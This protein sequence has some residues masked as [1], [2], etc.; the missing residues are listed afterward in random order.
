[1]YHFTECDLNIKSVAQLKDAYSQIGCTI[2]VADKR[3]K[4][5]WVQAILKHQSAQI[6][7][8]AVAEI[9]VDEQA[10]AQTELETHVALQAETEANVITTVEISFFDHEVYALG[11]QIAAITHDHSD[12][13]T[14]RWV[15]MVGGTEIHR[16]DSWAKCHSYI[17]WHYLQGTLVAA[18]T[19]IPAAS[20]NSLNFKPALS[21]NPEKTIYEVF[22]GV[23]SLGLVILSECGCWYNS[24]SDD[25][26]DSYATPYEAA[27]ALLPTSPN[28]PTTEIPEIEID[29]APD[30]DFGEMYRVWHGISLIGTF[31][32]AADD[33]WVAMP[34]NSNDRPSCNTA[35]EAQLLI[36]AIAGLLVADTSDDV[37]DLLDRP[38]DELTIAEWQAIKL[39]A[40]QAELVAA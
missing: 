40:Q 21:A 28:L 32:R 38:F 8:V 2:E 17:S 16:A 19:S 22:R 9:K 29:S 4:A 27:A 11:K 31:Y 10:V 7:L 15:A 14:Q 34:C 23:D 6:E 3:V 20:S 33:K 37:V 25:Y 39:A 35:A 12:F 30:P 24:D 13:Q 26:V 36:V 18:P 5:N 1:M